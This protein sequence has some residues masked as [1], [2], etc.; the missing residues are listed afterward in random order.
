MSAQQWFRLNILVDRA[1]SNDRLNGSIKLAFESIGRRP[2]V[3]FDIVELGYS[4]KRVLIGSG[5]GV[6]ENRIS[7]EQ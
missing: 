2:N 1:L 6:G 5:A 4:K 3:F 7:L